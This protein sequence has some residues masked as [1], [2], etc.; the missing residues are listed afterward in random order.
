M[1]ASWNKPVRICPCLPPELWLRIFDCATWIPG[2]LEPE[3]YATS[4]EPQRV[5]TRR[6]QRLLKDSLVTKRYL[7]RVCKQWYIWAT[8]TL[9]ETIIIGRGRTLS[10]LCSA[11]IDSKRK[12]DHSSNDH[13]H[14]GWYTKRLDIAMRDQGRQGAASE[15]DFLAEAIQCLPNLTIVMFSVRAPRYVEHPL[16]TSIMQALADTCGPTLRIV[17]FSESVLHPFRHDW[18]VL[19]AATSHLRVLR[20]PEATPI[21]SEHPR[22]LLDLPVLSELTALTLTSS[23]SK[24]YLTEENHFPSLRELEFHYY[25][26]PPWDT[27]AGPL[28]V[29]GHNLTAVRLDFNISADY[30]QGELDVLSQHCPNLMRL[31]LSLKLWEQLIDKLSLPSVSYL[32]LRCWQYQAPS[33]R[34]RRLFAN[35]STMYGPTL[36]RVCLCDYHNVADLRLRH[37]R[38]LAQGLE[39]ISHCP[40]RL[41]DHEGQTFT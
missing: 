7:V 4:D 11:L 8:P 2:V 32:A 15:L 19:L 22:P 37:A 41:E 17:D 27:W 34:Y 30:L 28:G 23:N 10:S 3:I 20:G 18:R 24:E 21:F 6:Q 29:F 13:H 9:Y 40:F 31:T 33:S 12:I 25:L 38:V 5:I 16:P 36:Q 26:P 1:S 14:L 39:Q 35:L